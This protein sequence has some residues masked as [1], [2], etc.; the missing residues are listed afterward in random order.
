MLISVVW[1]DSIATA[2]PDVEMWRCENFLE[3]SIQ[4]SVKCEDV[5]FGGNTFKMHCARILSDGRAEDI[6]WNERVQDLRQY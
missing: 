2:T 3:L 6:N 1:I 4:H 5:G